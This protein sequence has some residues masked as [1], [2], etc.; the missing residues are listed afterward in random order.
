MDIYIPQINLAIEI[1]G[2]LHFLPIYGLEK[3]TKIQ[4]KDT[5]KKTE[6]AEIRCELMVIDTS[7]IK[8]WKETKEFLDGKYRERI[9]PLIKTRL[10][11]FQPRF[12]RK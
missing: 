3:L 2:P 10:E 11:N 4:N 7:K 6:A 8:Y 12:K 5:Q 9:K 1:N